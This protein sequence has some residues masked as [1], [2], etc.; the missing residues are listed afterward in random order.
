MNQT[1]L[2]AAIHGT[3]WLI[4]LAV[5]GGG[6]AAITD[7]LDVP[8]ASRTLLEV[9]VPYAHTAMVD[10]L[11]G[12]PPDGA[13]SQLTAE[14]MAVACLERARF[15]A[16]DH[17]ELLGVAC[18]A[19]LVSDRPKK[20]EHRAHVAIASAAGVRHERVG[21]VKG[22]LDRPGEDRVVADAILRRLAAASGLQP[23]A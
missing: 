15:L 6:N 12:E 7:L 3:P 20:G 2:V 22:A 14:A 19:A 8:G 1:D 23:S 21:L 18:T 9:R 4:V 17:P 16:P 10:L 5:A 11:G 13:V